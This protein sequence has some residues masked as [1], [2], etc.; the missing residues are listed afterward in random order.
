MQ[1]ICSRRI[2]QERTVLEDVARGPAGELEAGVRYRAAGNG[3]EAEVT[4][5]EGGLA[6]AG[7][8]ELERPR[9]G[10]RRRTRIANAAE[11]HV[12]VGVARALVGP[13]NL[14]RT[15]GRETVEQADVREQAAA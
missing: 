15:T 7:R 8:A 13:T 3:V 2:H 4:A 12:P 10:V 11:V 6:V 1:R 14:C 9:T 5:V